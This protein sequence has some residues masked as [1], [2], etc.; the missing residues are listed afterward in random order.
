MNFKDKELIIKNDIIYLKDEPEN[1]VMM[2]WERPLMEKH[3]EIVC[4]NGG[5][6]LEIVFGLGISA[7]Y[8]QS[9]DIKSHTIVEIH[10]QIQ[11]KLKE[12]SINKE[13]VNIIN[14]DWYEKMY[15][16]SKNDYDGIL[17][18]VYEDFNYIYAYHFIDTL[19][20]GGIFSFFSPDGHNHFSKYNDN[21]HKM[22]INNIKIDNNNYHNEK[23]TY[24]CWIVK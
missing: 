2:E 19:K 13:N 12:W 8:R 20:P 23:D 4:K 9:H 6:I 15:E 22:E 17:F 16:L 11:K 10:P 18:D 1:C 14:G 21:F 3:A 5:N 24:C 7:D